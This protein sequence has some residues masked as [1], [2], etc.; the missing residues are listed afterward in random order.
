MSYRGVYRDGVVR[1][2][3]DVDLQ[4]GSRVEVSPERDPRLPRT[5]ADLRR[6]KAAGKAAAALWKRL[7]RKKMT[8]AE[9]LAAADA[10]YGM[11]KDRADWEGKTSAEISLELRKRASRRVT[12]G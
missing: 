2:E 1:L 3:G 4:E 10:A 7:A 9:R 5:A 11:Y 8:K 6:A 12:N